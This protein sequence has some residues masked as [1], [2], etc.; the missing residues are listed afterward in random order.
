MRKLVILVV[1][2]VMS[3]SAAYAD[4]RKVV[5]PVTKS[6][7]YALYPSRWGEF[8]KL[9]T[10]TGKIDRIVPSHPGKNQVLNSKS[11]ADNATPG[12]FE[13]Y[14]TDFNDEWLL[15][16]T[17]TGVVWMLKLNKKDGDTLTKIERE[18]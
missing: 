5:V 16:D 14:P 8:L 1:V 7:N 3:L 12:R 15:F 4:D 13:L 2:A 18:N 17:E 9:D 6:T 11:L 10:R